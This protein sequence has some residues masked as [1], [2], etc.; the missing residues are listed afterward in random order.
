[1]S[2]KILAQHLTCS[3]GCQVDPLSKNALSEMAF[4]EEQQLR[5]HLFTKIQQWPMVY[6]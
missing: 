2:N 6:I 5:K 4:V 1:M 3:S